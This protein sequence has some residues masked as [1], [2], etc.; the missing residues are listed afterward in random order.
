MVEKWLK[1]LKS[2]KDR[3]LGCLITS[4]HKNV[5]FEHPQKSCFEITDGTI[6]NTS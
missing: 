1:T 6:G 4:I 5:K 3:N 2:Y